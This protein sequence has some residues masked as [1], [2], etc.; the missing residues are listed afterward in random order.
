[1]VITPEKHNSMTTSFSMTIWQCT[2]GDFLKIKFFLSLFVFSL[3]VFCLIVCLRVQAPRSV[4]YAKRQICLI[5]NYSRETQLDDDFLFHD[6]L[7]VTT[8]TQWG[9]LKFKTLLLFVCLYVGSR[10]QAPRSFCYAKREIWLIGNYSRETQ[11]DD[12][13]LFHDDLAVHCGGFSKYYL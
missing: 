13:F 2:V 6:D 10:V 8:N 5:G 1:M 12:D 11:L 3:F 9:V 4:C 7:A